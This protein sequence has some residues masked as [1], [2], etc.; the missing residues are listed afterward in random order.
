VLKL[1]IPIS[2]MARCT[3]CD[4]VC[5]WL[6]VDRWIS[7]GTPVSSTNKYDSYYTTE[8]VLI[9]VLNTIT[10]TQIYS[11]YHYINHRCEM[12]TY[13]SILFEQPGHITTPLLPMRRGDWVIV[14]KVVYCWYWIYKPPSRFKLVCWAVIWH[15]KYD[16]WNMT[17][18]VCRLKYDV[19]SMSLKYEIWCKKCEVWRYIGSNTGRGARS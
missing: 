5:Q 6:T 4:K 13:P 7:P 18:E 16:V 9:V 17:S 1:W 10:I 15:L 8:I 2:L 14:S 3:L 19:W 12:I 11:V